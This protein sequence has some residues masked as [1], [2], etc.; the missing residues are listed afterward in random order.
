MAFLDVSESNLGKINTMIA[1][2][3][4]SFLSQKFSFPK[5]EIKTMEYKSLEVAKATVSNLKL[6]VREKVTNF[7]VQSSECQF[8]DLFHKGE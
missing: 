3:N 5:N 4:N 7:S 6:S 2:S 1:E 8:M